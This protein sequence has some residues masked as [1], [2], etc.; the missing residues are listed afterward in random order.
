MENEKA[1]KADKK[2]LGKKK[3]FI[4]IGALVLALAGGGGYYFFLGKSGPAEP[5]PGEVVALEPITLNLTDGHYLK[6]RLA[7]QATIDVETKVDGSK[8][9]DLAVSEFSNRPVA[10]L[11][12]DAAREASKASLKQKIADAY[13]GAVMDI[14]FTEFVME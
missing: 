14:Y 5:E 6:L 10:E 8:A 1:G 13:K 4:I 2:P 3:L 9:L 12:G 7:L 11:S